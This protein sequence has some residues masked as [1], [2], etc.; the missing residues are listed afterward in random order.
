MTVSER[1][2]LYQAMLNANGLINRLL[3]EHVPSPWE[4]LSI[5]PT[6]ELRDRWDESAKEVMALL[7]QGDPALASTEQT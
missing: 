4:S 2:I 7:K 3:A 6:D 1:R 5:P